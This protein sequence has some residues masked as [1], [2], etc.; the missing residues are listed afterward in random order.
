VAHHERLS[1]ITVTGDTVN[2]AA[3][4]RVL[5]ETTETSGDV[6]HG[7]A[8]A[9][10]PDGKLYWGLGD[11]GNGLNAQDL[12]TLRGKVLRINPD[13][14][15]LGARSEIYVVGLRNPYRFAAAPGN[16]LLVADVGS[17]S[18]EEVNLLM[19]GANYGWPQQEGFCNGCASVNP[20]Y[21]YPHGAGAA[22]TSVLVYTGSE[23]GPSFQNKVFIAD[24]IQ[25]WIKVLTCNSDYTSCGG[26]SMFDSQ[27][28][29]TIQL[30]Q[31]P[32]DNDIYQLTYQGEL[33]RIG[34]HRSASGAAVV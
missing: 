23:F 6:H 13:P 29:M 22:I 10:G 9:F 16:K 27:A 4:E 1:R 12:T 33:S 25:G 21:A 5:L 18:F 14:D 8:I 34:P 31:G 24:L 30:L 32:K 17:V 20:I 28:G 2:L 3:S 11:N 15:T 7:G 26:E 19:P